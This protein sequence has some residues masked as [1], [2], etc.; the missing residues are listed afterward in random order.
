[1]QIARLICDGWISEDCKTNK[2]NLYESTF[3]TI[4]MLFLIVFLIDIGCKIFG[5]GFKKYL[6]DVFNGPDFIIIVLSMI[7]TL[8]VLSLPEIADGAKDA[9]F[10]V[11]I[12]KVRRHAR[13]TVRP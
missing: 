9:T 5:L 2:L 13:L 4:D 10:F 7:L 1:M 8:I 11:P 12:F 6:W 3:N